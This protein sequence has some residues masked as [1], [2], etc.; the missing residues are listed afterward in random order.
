MSRGRYKE[1][2]I[3]T[4]LF[5]ISSFGSKFVSFFMLP[6]YT[7][8]LTTGDYGAVDLVNS[9]VGLLVP[10][11]TLNIQ[12]AVLR[13]GLGK[14]AEPEEIL[15]IGLRVVAGASCILLIVL[16]VIATIRVVPLSSTYFLFLYAMFVLTALSNVMTMYVKS[17]DHIGL[18]VVSGIGNTLVMCVSAV[19]LLVVLKVGV[20]GYMASMTLGSLFAVLYLFFSGKI[21]KGISVN[22]RPG[23]AKSMISFSLP[24]VANSLAWWVNDVSDR[25]VVTI[26]CGVAANGLYAVAYKIPT[27]LST[28]QSIFY[29]A[30]A[31]SAVKEFDSEDSDGFLGHTYELYSGLL[32]IC[33]SVIMFANIF[34]ASILYSEEFFG[35][36]RYVPLLLVSVLLNGLALFEG[37]IF[38]AARN[39]RAVSVTTA[40]GAIVS[41]A[42]CVVL[43]LVMGPVG[44]AF[45]TLIGYLITWITRTIIMLRKVASIRVSWV[46][47]MTTLVALVVQATIAMN[48]GLQLVQIPMTVLVVI[49]RRKQFK[50][51][52][53]LLR[54]L[55]GKIARHSS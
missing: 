11:F 23:L 37:C 27:I 49:L 31:I 40:V 51:V 2:G 43:T 39:T 18:L 10:L 48:E 1:L 24:L 33:C 38:T 4:A 19:L 5:A 26:I 8:M 55:P 12:D 54:S 50:V 30:W 32:A 9:T 29:N 53:K 7:A 41:I 35:A 15:S 34:L 13:Y 6:L 36:W 44:A 25:Y 47:E 28:L 21:W 52:W 46:I 16:M 42:S 3:N 17:Q 22:S 20:I 45:A 14:D